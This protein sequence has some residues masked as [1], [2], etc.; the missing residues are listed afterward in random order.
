MRR[1]ALLFALAVRVGSLFVSG[2]LRRRSGAG[3]DASFRRRRVARAATL[4]EGR[5][6]VVVE[7]PAAH[8]V[9]EAS[10]AALVSDMDASYNATAQIRPRDQIKAL[11]AAFNARDADAA[12]ALLSD[13]VVY[14]DLLLGAST[15]CRGK[16]AFAAALRWHPAFVASR[17]RLPIGGLK[18]IVD[19]VACNGASSVGVEWHVEYSNGQPF[20]LGRGL[21]M[22]TLDSEGKLLRV[23]DICEA[24]WR[25]VGLV[26][27][28]FLSVQVSFVVVS[29]VLFNEAIVQN[30]FQGGA[31]FPYPY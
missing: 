28:P 23:V 27:R 2:P 25:V 12:A 13:D 10:N 5:R 8:R 7:R 24:P 11:Y 19:E 14:E 18:L 17:L 21:S 1:C 4:N 3:V 31:V 9:G 20:P 22:A 15:I 30:V 29:A 26:V 16:E 6:S